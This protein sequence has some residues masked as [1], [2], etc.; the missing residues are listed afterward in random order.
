MTFE[1]TT[2]AEIG[3]SQTFAKDELFKEMN[4]DVGR[5]STLTDEIFVSTQTYM[6]RQTT[7]LNSKY[8]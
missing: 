7:H 4:V 8:Y 3:I 2:N 5:L 1:F 6:Q